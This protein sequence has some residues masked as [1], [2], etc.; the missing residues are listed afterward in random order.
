[1]RLAFGPAAR[2]HSV[3]AGTAFLLAACAQEPTTVP[4][5]SALS[6][7]NLS[8]DTVAFFAY[9]RTQTYLVDPVAAF[10]LNPS[11]AAR[12]VAPGAAASVPLTDLWGYRPGADVRLFVYTVSASRATWR[13]VVDATGAQLTTSRFTIEIPGGT[14]R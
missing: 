10:D 2:R 9:E 12:V 4:G 7:R 14:P 1:M 5:V 6:V 13:G 11:Q 3:V 8:A